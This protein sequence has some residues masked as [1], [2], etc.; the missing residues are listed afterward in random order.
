MCFRRMCIT[1]I[2]FVINC[3][4]ELGDKKQTSIVLP[5]HEKSKQPIVQGVLG[6]LVL[7]YKHPL[8]NMNM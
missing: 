5:L 8:R 7:E 3:E 4:S 6:K 1:T 2:R